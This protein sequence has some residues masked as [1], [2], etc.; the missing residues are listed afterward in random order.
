L[1]FVGVPG[2]ICGALWPGAVPVSYASSNLAVAR[3]V[4]QW[5]V[6]IISYSL[7][8]Q[9]KAERKKTAQKVN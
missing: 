8:D 1:G 5:S 2:S 6:I 7:Y 3:C 9:K 4:F